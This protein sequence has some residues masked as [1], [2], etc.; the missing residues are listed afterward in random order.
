MRDR[1]ALSGNQSLG[2]KHKRR[3]LMAVCL[4]SLVMLVC[5]A[6]RYVNCFRDNFVFLTIEE[7][8]TLALRSWPLFW[9]RTPQAY[10]DPAE[11]V[12]EIP[13]GVSLMG[14]SL[15]VYYSAIGQGVEYFDSLKFSRTGRSKVALLEPISVKT[16]NWE[17][18]EVD[19]IDN[20]SR[21]VRG[22][23]KVTKTT[24]DGTVHLSYGKR[25]IVLAAGE[26]WAELI[27]KTPQGIVEV[28]ALE[29][30]GALNE[31]YENQWPATRLAITNYGLWPKA[32]V[33]VGVIP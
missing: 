33:K 20:Y 16:R 22:D 6:V 8:S 11:K 5:L 13:S 4:V 18:Q 1:L 27:L 10:Y 21:V 23:L 28:D 7:S 17:G 31:A 15:A 14:V 25:Q 24:P 29:W 26:T 12:L 9:D 30:R 19:I 2:V 3:R 32:S